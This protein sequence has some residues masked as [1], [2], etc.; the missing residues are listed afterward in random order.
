[1]QELNYE[2]I[3][4]VDRFARERLAP[5]I[6][7]WDEAGGAPQEV[8]T[9]MAE[10][11]LFGLLARAE[12][13][14]LELD[15]PTFIRIVERLAYHGGGL[16]TLLH[17]HNFTMET[18]AMMAMTGFSTARNAGSPTAVSPGWPWSWP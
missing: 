1:M 6:V 11:G 9:E 2:L 16:S 4:A 3:E 18:M 5:N 12:V 17:V 13:G 7:E 14:G 15:F 10:L 8:L